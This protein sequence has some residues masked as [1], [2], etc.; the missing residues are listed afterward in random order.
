MKKLYIVLSLA[1]AGAMCATAA[2]AKMAGM[3]KIG[4]V[5]TPE[6]LPAT[7]VTDKGFTANWKTVPGA[8]GYCLFVTARE[9]VTAP[10]RKVVLYE[11]FGLVS[12]GSVIEP[13]YCE[14]YTTQLDK[15]DL[16][17]TPDWIISQCIMAGGKISGVIWTPNMDLR[18]DGGKYH[19]TATIQGYSGMEIVFAASGSK[20]ETQKVI[21]TSEGNNTIDLDFTNGCQET[22]IR[23]VDNGFPDDTEGMYI[24]K[25]AYLDDI[26]VTQM[27]QAGEDVYRLVACESIDADTNPHCDFE[28]LPFGNGEKRFYYDVYAA[29]YVYNDPFDDW[30]YDVYYSDFSPK[31][32]VLLE[33]YQGVGEIETAEAAA[34]FTA[35][36]GSIRHN[37]EGAY[38]IF[39][40]A[41]R[42]VASGRG[43]ATVSLGAGVYL[44]RANGTT[45]KVIVK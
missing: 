41:G 20:D 35:D 1:M 33:G 36:Y 38:D 5:A 29:M 16:T 7:N 19:V 8:D 32:E 25:I 42:K 6:V 43:A 24:D 39:D 10:G 11:D 23:I 15:L 13:Y 37:G 14:E 12:Q 22:Y 30:D 18:A 9:E 45:S 4:A 17:Y 34:D 28:T 2:P 21:L 3:K 40:L 27:Y 26:E 31:Q 44:T